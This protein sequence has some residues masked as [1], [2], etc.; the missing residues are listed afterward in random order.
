MPSYAYNASAIGLGGVIRRGDISTVV[1]TVASVC[2]APAGG[3]ASISYE[4]YNRHDISFTKAQARVGGYEA[5]A[6]N[7]GLRRHITYADI[8][9][10][11]L[12]I[13][14]RLK[15]TFMQAT[16]TSSREVGNERPP[17][18]LEHDLTEFEINVLYRGVVIDGVEVFPD[19]DANLCGAKK[20][21][22]FA[23][24]MAQRQDLLLSDEAGITP[25]ELAELKRDR[26]PFNG[27]LIRK[28]ENAPSSKGHKVPLRQFGNA[29][30]AELLVKP[31][32]QRFSL[33]R[34]DLNSD[35]STVRPQ[36]DG[37]MFAAS[38]DGEILANAAGDDGQG[39]ALSG[40]GGG[41][42]G[43]PIWP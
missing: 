27:S 37:P 36:N 43:V 21:G 4:N 7:G 1:P 17:Q 29:K 33:L 12:K 11:N 18:E 24:L 25:A 35:W 13:F 3:E 16:I 5:P 41:S 14:D 38:A 2:L 32:R 34:L 42:N 15:I 23:D 28:I 22:A 9:L 19:V 31:D 8:Y 39:G 10:S 40:G 26:K 20:Y 6:V 30:F